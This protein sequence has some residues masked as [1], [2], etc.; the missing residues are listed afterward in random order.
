MQ[1]KAALDASLDYAQGLCRFVLGEDNR[2]CNTLAGAL[3]RCYAATDAAAFEEATAAYR[4]G[5]DR[6]WRGA[7]ALAVNVFD[8][9][10]EAIVAARAGASNE[11]A[12]RL[13][14]CYRA[15]DDVATAA[16]KDYE[17]RWAEVASAHARAVA[18]FE[19]AGAWRREREAWRLEPDQRLHPDAWVDEVL[20][21]VELNL[22]RLKADDPCAD[23]L[24]ALRASIAEAPTPGALGDVDERG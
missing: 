8:C 4:E 3:R 24:R 5:R 9:A 11:A 17:A 18:A 2:A 23:A 20:A 22:R 15:G 7:G 19:E 12:R 14:A 6:D 21:A 16:L 1:L 10:L 13:V